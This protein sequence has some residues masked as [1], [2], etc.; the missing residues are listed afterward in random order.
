MHSTNTDQK[1][2]QGKEKTVRRVDLFWSPSSRG[3]V[4]HASEDI[5]QFLP[6]TGR[7]TAENTNLN[8][9]WG[10]AFNSLALETQSHQCDPT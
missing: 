6:R 8:L 4:S 2:E 9:G 7:I 10:T 5:E 3:P 1:M